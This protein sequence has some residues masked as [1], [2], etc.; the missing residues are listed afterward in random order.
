VGN[1][2]RTSGSSR[3]GAENGVREALVMSVLAGFGA[4]FIEFVLIAGF[5][6]FEPLSKKVIDKHAIY[7]WI[8]SPL[9]FNCSIWYFSRLNARGPISTWQVALRVV[10]CLPAR[11]ARRE[12]MARPAS[13]DHFAFHRSKRMQI[14]HDDRVLQERQ[15]ER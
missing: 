5:Y 4:V 7:L 2:S 14:A 3:K 13:R 10:G 12:G 8:V 11:P 6:L 15:L 9:I 1:L